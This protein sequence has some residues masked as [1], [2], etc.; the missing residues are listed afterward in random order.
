MTFPFR[1]NGNG[2]GFCVLGNGERR[3]TKREL[4]GNGT[5]HDYALYGRGTRARAHAASPAS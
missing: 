1:L 2:D 3:S 4:N 5:V